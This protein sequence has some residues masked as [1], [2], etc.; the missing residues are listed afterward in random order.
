MTYAVL[1][2]LTKKIVKTRGSGMKVKS[3]NFISDIYSAPNVIHNIL[4]PKHFYFQRRRQA[5]R[6]YISSKRKGNLTKIGN[7]STGKYIFLDV[8]TTYEVKSTFKVKPDDLYKFDSDSKSLGVDNHASKYMSN[9][10][11]DFIAEI[12]PVANMSVK[13]VGGLLK[14]IGKGT[15]K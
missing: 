7:K 2:T 12:T 8:N 10:K 6:I 14:V 11:E 13:G 5:Q 1:N 3:K 4:P 15:V 9:D